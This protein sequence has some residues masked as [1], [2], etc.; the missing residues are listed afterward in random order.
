MYPRP[1]HLLFSCVRPVF[2]GALAPPNR[3]MLG[4]TPSDQQQSS[5]N[6]WQPRTDAAC[7]RRRPIHGAAFAEPRRRPASAHCC[8]RGPVPSPP[9]AAH[10]AKASP[11]TSLRPLRQGPGRAEGARPAPCRPFGA[12]PLAFSHGARR[13]SASASTCARGRAAESCR[14]TTTAAPRCGVQRAVR[15]Q[16]QRPQRGVFALSSARRCPNRSCASATAS[17]V[18]SELRSRG[19]CPGASTCLNK[20]CGEGSW[21]PQRAA[22]AHPHRRLGRMALMPRSDTK[23]RHCKPVPHDAAHHDNHAGKAAR[24]WPRSSGCQR[25]SAQQPTPTCEPGGA[26]T[27]HPQCLC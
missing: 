22:T 14:L 13:S 11:A 23:R 15:L 21:S 4:S 7:Q 10:V 19:G 26:R 27:A 9:G 25:Q 12:A 6:S 1:L 8:H 2:V 3:C 5:A 16:R 24:Q 17:G 20:A 18:C